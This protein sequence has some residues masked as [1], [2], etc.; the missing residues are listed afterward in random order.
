MKTNLTRSLALLLFIF[1]ISF[2]AEAQKKPEV[3]L[4]KVFVN[5]TDS[6]NKFV[7]KLYDDQ[8]YEFLKFIKNKKISNVKREQGEYSLKGKKLNLEPKSDKLPFE[9]P[10]SYYFIEDM[11]LFENKKCAGDA[12]L[13]LSKD[14]KFSQAFYNDPVFGKISNDRKLANK[15][16]DPKLNAKNNS[17]VTP[18]I[19]TAAATPTVKKENVIGNFAKLSADSLKKIKVIIVVGP[20]EESTKHF[21]DEKKELATFL[22]SYGVQVKEFYHPKANWADVKEG[23][24]DAHIFIY[25]GHGSTQGENSCS[26]GLCLSDGITSASD[27]SKGLQLN[28]NALILFN[29]VCRG[30]GS[31]ASD[32]GDIGKIEAAKRV[33]D[34]SYPFIQKGAGCYYANNTNGALQPFLERFFNKMPVS[35]IWKEVSKSKTIVIDEKYKHDKRFHISLGADDDSGAIITRTT[36]TNGVKKVEKIKGSISYDAAYVSMPEFNVLKFFEK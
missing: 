22:R 29:H 16:N 7:L 13:A 18:E 1:G 5:E 33:T 23:S 15:L 9:H 20:V 8:S 26:G 24:K 27:M 4:S 36:T 35:A 2:I 17:S 21:I 6:L 25:S 3:I 31:S 10:Y 28:K 14:E 11:G 19:V 34:Y 12:T 32:D 30:A